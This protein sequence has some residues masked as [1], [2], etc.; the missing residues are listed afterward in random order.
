MKANLPTRIGWLC[1]FFCASLARCHM[2]CLIPV[3][4]LTTNVHVL[5]FAKEPLY[6]LHLPWQ[7]HSLI[8][9]IPHIMQGLHQT[10]C[11]A[12]FPTEE[13]YRLL[14]AMG[15]IV[16]QCQTTKGD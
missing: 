9:F 14:V 15:W 12:K 1:V 10:V 11:L 7:E 4:S 5:R 16:E 13:A 6:H 8:F 3:G 2:G